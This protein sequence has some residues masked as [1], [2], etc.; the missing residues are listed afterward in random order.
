MP[1][2]G[3]QIRAIHVVAGEELVLVGARLKFSL[4]IAEARVV[5]RLDFGCPR[6]HASD[7][8]VLQVEEG[9]A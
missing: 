9:C 7:V 3:A 8:H 2:H 1:P 6:A 5:L 4:L